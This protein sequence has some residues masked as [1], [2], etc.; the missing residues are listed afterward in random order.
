MWTA[1]WRS[2][3]GRWVPLGVTKK[4]SQKF[5]QLFDSPPGSKFFLVNDI[6]MNSFADFKDIMARLLR[7]P[8]N[9]ILR[10]ENTGFVPASGCSRMS[11]IQWQK[12]E[13]FKFLSKEVPIS[14]RD[15]IELLNIKFCNPGIYVMM[16]S[17]ENKKV[18]TARIGDKITEINGQRTEF[19]SQ[20]DFEVEMS[21]GITNIFYT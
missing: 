19:M 20:F 3:S 9:V 5:A 16:S 6:A 21:K 12:V 2:Y 4:E 1:D 8:D 10:V 14:N 15:Q 7:T 17:R 18:T 13:N 11:N